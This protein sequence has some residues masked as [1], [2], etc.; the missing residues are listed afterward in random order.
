MDF[1]DE[2]SRV[3]EEWNREA[4]DRMRRAEWAM[5]SAVP[6][7]ECED[8]GCLIPEARRMAVPGCVTCVRCQ[9]LRE[10]RR[11]V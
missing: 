5:K 9:V 6:V 8:C 3:Y 11:R 2:A 1:A 10:N 7:E 4:I